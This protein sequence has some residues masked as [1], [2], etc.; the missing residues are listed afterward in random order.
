MPPSLSLS[1]S[2][3]VIVI[4]VTQFCHHVPDCSIKKGKQDVRVEQSLTS[5]RTWSI[6]A[7]ACI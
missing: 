7:Q 3:A 4:R 2:G 6:L 5:C 1:D